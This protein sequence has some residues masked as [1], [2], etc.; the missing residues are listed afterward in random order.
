MDFLRTRFTP[1]DWV[2][3]LVK[4]VRIGRVAQRIVPIELASSERVRSWLEREQQRG[5]NVYV[6]VNGLRAKTASRRRQDVT[7]VR[8]VFLDADQR[9]DEVVAAIQDRDDMPLL[10]YV[11]HTS[12][13]RAQLFWRVQGFTVDGVEALQR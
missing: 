4:C 6:S 2:A 1:E 11:L 9:A 10:S 3:L 13:G 8:H 5:C 12:P 7:H